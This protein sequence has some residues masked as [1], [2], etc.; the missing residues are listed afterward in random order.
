M[1]PGM[2][3]M[4]LVQS[5]AGSTLPVQSIWLLQCACVVRSTS[6][7]NSQRLCL[8]VLQTQAAEEQQQQQ[9]QGEKE[10]VVAKAAVQGRKRTA[11][12]RLREEEAAEDGG[13]DEE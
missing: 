13:A 7:P 6:K 9:Q 3:L 1:L 4:Q 10:A 5:P 8:D 2:Q 12:H 11:A